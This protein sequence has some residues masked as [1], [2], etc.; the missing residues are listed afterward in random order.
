MIT[1]HRPAPT[2]VAGVTAVA[3]GLAGSRWGAYLGAPPIFLTD[4]LIVLAFVHFA[5]RQVDPAVSPGEP[6]SR[7]HWLFIALPVWAFLGYLVGRDHG[8]T[9]V[10]DVLPYLYAA[11][12]ILGA[13]A[14]ARS[15]PEG[16]ART[17][18][19]IR[20]ALAFHTAWFA[21]VSMWP[22]L[23]LR[24]PV[25]GGQGLHV[26]SPRN[27]FDTAIVGVY[28]A[29]L[30]I[31]LL[32]GD[33]RRRRLMVA[34]ALSWVTVIHTGSRAGLIG[35]LLVT[36]IALSAAMASGT[37]LSR[38]KVTLIAVMPILLAA[39]VWAL[40]S[41]TIGQ[42]L[43]GTIG[44]EQSAAALS[45]EGTAN[46]RQHA[47]ERLIDYST[48]DQSRMVLGV[49]YG[50]DF[51][52]DSGAL[53]LLIGPG[54]PGQETPR[55]P[56]NYW[57]GTL[58]R[59]GLIGLGLFV[60]LAVKILQAARTRRACLAEDPLLLFAALIPVGLLIPASL[61]VILESPFGAVPFFWCAGVLLAYPVIRPGHGMDS[62]PASTHVPPERTAN[63]LPAALI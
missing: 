51:L 13:G 29:D 11:V 15:T 42:R 8:L 23:A 24:M 57:L 54:V 19:L 28:I 6:P 7:P 32:R 59:G 39:V 55:S 49:G 63:R 61:G 22:A 12:G 46:A 4:I 26:F 20:G 44:L 33:P 58:L 25:V 34:F 38:R 21:A 14:V 45:A 52:A 37:V 50:P 31:R 56:H 36:L 40:P 47:W 3:L 62:G 18:R 41:T 53:H 5:V 35:A 1:D 10:R 2:M 48:E 43:L 17:A 60:W 30:L 16:R 27:D 9:A